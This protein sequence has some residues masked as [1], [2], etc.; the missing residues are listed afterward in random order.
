MDS[1]GHDV[2][3]GWLLCDA[4][5]ALGDESL[6]EK[7]NQLALDVTRTCLAEGTNKEMGC[8]MYEKVGDKESKRCSWWGQIE[9]MIACVNAWQ[10]S[11]DEAYLRAADTVWNFVKGNMIDTEYGEWYSD[12]FDGKPSKDAPKVSMWRCPYHTVRFGVEMYNRLK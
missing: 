8:M 9:T 11:G 2:E 12:C 3:T 7:T 4:A 10:I 6:I 5:H 1:Y